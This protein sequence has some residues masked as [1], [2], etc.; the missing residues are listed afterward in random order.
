MK[1]LTDLEAAVRTIPDFPKPGIQFKDLSRIYED[2]GLLR[3]AV[4]RLSRPFQAARITIVVGIEA[5]GF[6]LGPALALRVGAGFTTVRKEGKLPHRTNSVSYG[7]EYGQDTIEIHADALAPDARVLIYD[8]VLATGGTASA[9]H[10]LVTK[11]GAEVV[12]YSFLMEL[13]ALG[14]RAALPKGPVFRALL[15]A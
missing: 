13:V 2:P 8:D 9:C 11:S 1:S 7:L 3:T 10:E 14:G 12:G 15:S 6:I 5:R 4:E